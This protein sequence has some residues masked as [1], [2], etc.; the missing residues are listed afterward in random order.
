MGTH[1]NES[2]CVRPDE[3]DEAGASSDV[4]TDDTVRLGESTSDLRQS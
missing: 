2:R 3:V 4:S 1:E